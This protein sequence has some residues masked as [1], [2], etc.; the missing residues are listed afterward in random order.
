MPRLLTGE[1]DNKLYIAL[2]V[3]LFCY[4]VHTISKKQSM[5]VNALL[6]GVLFALYEM[7]LE[8]Q[9]NQ[10]NGETRVKE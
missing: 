3:A 7:I 5:G 4:I 8:E 9:V 2:E 1:L 10:K 6:T